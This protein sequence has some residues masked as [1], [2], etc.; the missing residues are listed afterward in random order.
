MQVFRLARYVRCHDLSGYG[1]FL[2]GGRW[3]L[4]GPSVRYTAESRSLAIIELLVHLT[5]EELPAGMYMLT[6]DVPDTSVRLL[7]AA[8]RPAAS[9][10][11]GPVGSAVETSLSRSQ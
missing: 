8:R 1:A 5:S 11:A 4:R 2:Y 3:N 6:L 10:A 9:S 7:T